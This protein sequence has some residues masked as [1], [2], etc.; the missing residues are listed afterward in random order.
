[1]TMTWTS[2]TRF[3]FFLLLSA[4]LSGCQAGVTTMSSSAPPLTY[5]NIPQRGFA[6][7]A[8]TTQMVTTQVGGKNVY[9]P[10]T[11]VIAAGDTHTLSIYNT[12]DGPHGFQIVG[13]GVEVVLNPGEE[14]HI[15][16]NDLEGGNIYQIGCQLHPP[17]RT[18]TLVVMKSRNRA[19]PLD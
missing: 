6:S 15:V 13:L 14:T 19:N 17:H 12:T 7:D 1:M 3:G 11:V 4:V 8:A 10:S 2:P 16:L 9:I 18:A 5:T